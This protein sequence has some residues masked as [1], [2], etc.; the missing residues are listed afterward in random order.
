[1][2]MT[3]FQKKCDSTAGECCVVVD[4]PVEVSSAVTSTA[5]Q[6]TGGVKVLLILHT[7]AVNAG[8]ELLGAKWLAHS[9]LE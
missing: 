4:V 9:T 2:R 8:A 7:S 6:A 1:M 3:V 5:V